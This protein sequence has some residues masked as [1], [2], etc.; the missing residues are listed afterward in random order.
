MAITVTETNLLLKGTL[1]SS[2][3]VPLNDSCRLTV[4]HDKMQLRATI[5]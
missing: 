4:I 2:Y 3:N 1:V 5:K